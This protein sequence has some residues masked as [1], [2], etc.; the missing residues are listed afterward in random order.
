LALRN[1]PAL[2]RKLGYAFADYALLRQA[3]THRSFSSTNNERLEFLGD[4]ILDALVAKLLYNTFTYL[5]EGELSRF[6][7]RLVRQ[8]ALHEVAV[9][10]DLGDYLQ[11]GEGELKSGGFRRPSIL[12]DAFEAI[13]GAIWLDG[14]YDAA[15]DLIN[16]LFKARVAA[17]DPKTQGKDNKSLL[18]EWLQAHRI[19]LPLYEVI[20]TM[21]EAHEQEFTVCCT[22]EKLAIS[23][24]GIGMSRRAAEQEAAQKAY[25]ILI[26]L[27]VKRAKK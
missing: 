26:A 6:R 16:R 1:L 17:L 19:E 15:E 24:Q 14:G 20:N 5:S 8:D 21:G 4:G 23:A 11:M 22:I 27:P 25:Q 18:Q 2:E 10:L 9:E 13:L 7:S 3:L 12:A